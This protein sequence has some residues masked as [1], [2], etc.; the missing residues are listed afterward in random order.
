MTVITAA[1]PASKWPGW[2]QA[3]TRSPATVNLQV[4]SFVS[5]TGSAN[6]LGSSGMDMMCAP[7]CA[8]IAACSSW[9]AASRRT[10][11]A[12]TLRCYPPRGESVKRAAQPTDDIGTSEETE[13]R[14]GRVASP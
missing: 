2:W 5:P 11:R 1:I 13:C 9:V 12:G 8:I 6:A 10:D 4:S 3:I 7:I 14:A